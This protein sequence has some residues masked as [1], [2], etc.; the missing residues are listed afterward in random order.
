MVDDDCSLVTA[1]LQVNFKFEADLNS[2]EANS[3]LIRYLTISF[4]FQ[5]KVCGLDQTCHKYTWAGLNTLYDRSL[6]VLDETFF[7]EIHLF[8]QR[9]NLG[10][11][12]I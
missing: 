8:L 12:P 1:C 6:L 11:S 3:G 7:R 5:R 9:K 4:R 2:K 10:Y